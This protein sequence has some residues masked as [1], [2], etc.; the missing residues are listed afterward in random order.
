MRFTTSAA[1]R[2]KKSPLGVPPGTHHTYEP[3]RGGK[4]LGRDE[5]RRDAETAA[6]VG[7]GRGYLPYAL[8]RSPGLD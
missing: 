8:E 2:R 4:M 5:L 3:T 6:G 1:P 7:W